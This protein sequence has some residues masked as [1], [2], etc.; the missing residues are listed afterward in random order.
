MVFLIQVEIKKLKG[1]LGPD[2][3]CFMIIFGILFIIHVRTCSSVAHQQM[4]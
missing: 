4:N 2:M 1:S 3:Y